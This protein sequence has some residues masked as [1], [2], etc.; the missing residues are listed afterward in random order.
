MKEEAKVASELKPLEET[1]EQDLQKAGEKVEKQLSRRILEDAELKEYRVAGTEEEWKDALKK[2]V[3]G[4]V[5]IPISK[6][7][8]GDDAAGKGSSGKKMKKGQKKGHKKH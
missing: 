7:R 1:L 2:G 5:S 6:K 3:N 4:L 8:D